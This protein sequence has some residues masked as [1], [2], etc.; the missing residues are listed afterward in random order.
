ML[1]N[2]P[3]SSSLFSM[4]KDCKGKDNSKRTTIAYM[5]D[6]DIIRAQWGQGLNV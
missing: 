5:D 4:Y 1:V 6:A 2:L 3:V